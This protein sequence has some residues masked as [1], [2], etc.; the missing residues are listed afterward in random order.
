[1]L[2]IHVLVFL[3]PSS[4]SFSCRLLFSFPV[5]TPTLIDDPSFSEVV[6]V[7]W[8][9]FIGYCVRFI[10]VG[11]EWLQE[12]HEHYGMDRIREWKAIRRR[13]FCMDCCRVFT[14]GALFPLPTSVVF[15]H[16]VCRISN[17]QRDREGNSSTAWFLLVVG[18]GWPFLRLWTTPLLV[19]DGQLLIVF[20][21]GD[22]C[23]AICKWITACWRLGERVV[24]FSIL[25]YWCVE[26]SVSV[27]VWIRYSYYP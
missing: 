3:Y 14:I 4:H 2:L 22:A 26:W 5:D 18:K 7:K 25:W 21:R 27:V 9:D 6:L 11:A 24:P 23:V 8:N 12:G 20:V 1:M 15:A 19:L 16:Q 10:S 17:H 13:L